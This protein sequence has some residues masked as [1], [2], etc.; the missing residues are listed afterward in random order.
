MTDG[1]IQALHPSFERRRMVSSR[2]GFCI[3]DERSLVEDELLP[4]QHVKPT[5]E[6]R[7]RSHAFSE[8]W[9][10]GKKYY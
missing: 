10:T 9:S 2:F 4:E 1:Y 7:R 3:A 5:W 8:D 6:P